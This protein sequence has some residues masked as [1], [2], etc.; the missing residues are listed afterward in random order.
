M[1]VL[2]GV[3]TAYPRFMFKIPEAEAAAFADALIAVEDE[4]AFKKLVER[5]GVRRSSPDFWNYIDTLKA[6]VRRRDPTRAG[7][8]D[9]DRY[10]NL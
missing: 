3:Q 9:V 4:T 7:A 5:W 1:S 8:L 10:L 6:F 2:E